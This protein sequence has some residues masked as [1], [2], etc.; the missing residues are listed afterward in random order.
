MVCATR[1]VESARSRVA[2]LGRQLRM[3][4]LPNTG[5]EPAASE[6]HDLL[7]H[8]RFDVESAREAAAAVVRRNLMSW[9]AGH[10]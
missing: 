5:A 4:D 2:A 3:V 1:N 8:V 7:A 9:E 10:A 6:L